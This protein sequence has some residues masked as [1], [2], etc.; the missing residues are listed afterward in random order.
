MHLRIACEEDVDAML[1]IYTPYVLETPISFETTPPPRPEFRQRLADVQKKFPW[2]VCEVEGKVIGYA[3]ASPFK[4]RAA[5]DWSVESSIYLQRGQHQKG[6]GKKLYAH[7]I[8][9]LQT[10][11]I[12][13]VIGGMAL[14]NAAS[15][16]LHESL[17]FKQVAQ[18][19]N[20]GYKFGQ[21]WDVGYWQLELQRSDCRFR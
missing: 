20:V 2:I 17:G 3:Y 6:I 21:W 13:N 14:P 12:A 1:S 8:E 19:K 7:L 16:A 11:G 18:F 10:Q 5:Y 15:K 4:T 9:L